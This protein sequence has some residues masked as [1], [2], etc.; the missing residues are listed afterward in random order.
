MTLLK[1]NWEPIIEKALADAS[2]LKPNEQ[3]N[4]LGDKQKYIKSVVDAIKKNIE[5]V[6]GNR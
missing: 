3:K 2:G 6:G 4:L 5:R 1:I